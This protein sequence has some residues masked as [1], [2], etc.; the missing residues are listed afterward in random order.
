M[1]NKII[2]IIKIIRYYKNWPTIFFDYLHL[3]KNKKIIYILRN[4]IKFKVHSKTM[5]KGLINSILLDK[6]YTPPGYEIKK[7]DIVVDI[8]AHIG[9][10]SIFAAVNAKYGRVYSYEPFSE[11]FSLIQE[12]IKLNN[13]TN[14][15]PFKLAVGGVKEKRNL[16]INNEQNGG[17]SLF[18]NYLCQQQKEGLSTEVVD[19]I[20]LKDIFSA[21]GIEKID[22]L[23][24]DCEGS[25]YEIL[26]STHSN[27]FRRVR[28]ISMEY[29]EFWS[30]NHYYCYEELR[31]LFE[32]M[33]FA[34]KHIKDPV[35]PIGYLYA[36]RLSVFNSEV[37]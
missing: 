24:I 34:V 19:G 21:N 18:K 17:H 20:T 11:N 29:H 35:N 23:K 14:I 32:K 2:K 36:K 22:F 26:F 28:K 5:E 25:E 30:N 31:K 9:V 13:L 3:L 7:R 33:G 10:F 8:G 27:I 37:L 6:K 4:G 16:Y 12:N 15:K 1:K